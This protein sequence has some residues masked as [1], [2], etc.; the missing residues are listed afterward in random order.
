MDKPF[1][2]TDSQYVSDVEMI[3]YKHIEN[4]TFNFKIN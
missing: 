4:V 1:F 2:T 3:N